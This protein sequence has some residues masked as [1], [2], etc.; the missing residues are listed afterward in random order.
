IAIKYISHW[1]ATMVALIGWQGF[2]GASVLAEDAVIKS[3]GIVAVDTANSIKA[4][5]SVAMTNNPEADKAW[6][7]VIKASQ[8]PMIPVAWQQKQPT[9]E[10]AQAFFVPLLT[11]G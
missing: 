5:N 10:E 4:T 9:L 3:P 8:A 11:A 7:E 6:K 1:C 2:Y